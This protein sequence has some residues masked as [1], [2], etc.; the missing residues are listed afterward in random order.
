MKCVHCNSELLLNSKFCNFCG[1]SIE[2][3][4]SFEPIE[5]SHKVLTS[6]DENI[7]F[8]AIKPES[9]IYSSKIE[10]E[11]I[12]E[13]GVIYLAQHKTFDSPL[14]WGT[15]LMMLALCV[16]LTI[17]PIWYRAGDLTL[18]VVPYVG[19]SFQEQK[20]VHNDGYAFLHRDEI[21][22]S[23][24]DGIYRYDT[25][26]ENETLI[27]DEFGAYIYVT[28][29]YL[30][31]CNSS[32]DYYKYS[33]ETKEKTHLISDAYYVQNLGDSIYYQNDADGEKIYCYDVVSGDSVKISNEA[34]FNITINKEDGY[35]Y[36]INDADGLCQIEISTSIRLLLAN[37]VRDYYF[38]GELIYFVTGDNLCTLDVLDK[39]INVVLDKKKI[40][41]IT[42]IDGVILCDNIIDGPFILNED[43]T[44]E[45][46]NLGS[47]MYTQILGDSIIYQDSDNYNLYIGDAT[48][49]KVLF[50]NLSKNR[51]SYK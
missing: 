34:S 31:Y 15:T 6:D 11:I 16:L 17:F 10:E 29:D 9:I 48:G 24:E 20:N 38:N 40:H 14:I 45:Y 22:L 47:M 23:Y 26:F 4:T 46:I 7:E 39:D 32:N 2:S 1:S 43:G 18:V 35:I 21:Y 25:D 8:N 5:V 27:I 13:D 49:K 51:G 19:D 12:E 50:I 36:Y 37:D 30:Y 33:F 44:V 28:D 41:Y 42:E 3:D